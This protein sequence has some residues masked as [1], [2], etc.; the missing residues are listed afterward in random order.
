MIIIILK[1][2]KNHVSI[3][4]KKK[5]ISE[6]NTKYIEFSSDFSD[7]EDSVEENSDE[8]NY[9]VENKYRMCLF[10]TF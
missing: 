6:Y 9:N 4:L 7:R 2:F 1:C 5:N 3:F 8:E 10:K